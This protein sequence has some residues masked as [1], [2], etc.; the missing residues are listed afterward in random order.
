MHKSRRKLTHYQAHRVASKHQNT[1]SWQPT[2][3]FDSRSQKPSR[4]PSKRTRKNKSPTRGK[5]S[6]S[7]SKRPKTTPTKMEN[8]YVKGL[9]STSGLASTKSKATLIA[10]TAH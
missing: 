8:P 1:Q 3:S 6:C 2:E 7:P 10:G 5:C 9:L 4:T